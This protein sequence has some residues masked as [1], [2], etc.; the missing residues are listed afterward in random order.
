M[1]Q[2]PVG[3]IC[4]LLSVVHDDRLRGDDSGSVGGA[5]IFWKDGLKSDL[6]IAAASV[7]LAP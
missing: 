4:H 6:T 5:G 7:K 2:Q 3:E 1:D